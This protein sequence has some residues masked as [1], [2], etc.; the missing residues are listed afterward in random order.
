MVVSPNIHSKNG[1]FRVPTVDGFGSKPKIS[2]AS[3]HVWRDSLITDPVVQLPRISRCL[4]PPRCQI[5]M[6]GTSIG[7]ILGGSKH[8]YF[9][10]DKKVVSFHQ[11]TVNK[12]LT[13]CRGLKSTLW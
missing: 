2:R 11:V 8:V 5:R 12:K 6:M 7:H 3:R 13:R 1:L 4:A 10:C 9:L